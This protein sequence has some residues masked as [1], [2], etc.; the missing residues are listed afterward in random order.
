M[1]NKT[2][3]KIISIIL[4]LTLIFQSIPIAVTAQEST[5][6]AEVTESDDVYV[7]GEDISPRE[8]SVKYF[9]MSDGSYSA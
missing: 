9:R 5:E 6:I 3:L 2:Y 8:E 1:K 7:I 4:T